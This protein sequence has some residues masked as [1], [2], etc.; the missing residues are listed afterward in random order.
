METS[1]LK[2]DGKLVKETLKVIGNSLVTKTGC[3]IYFPKHYVD[4]K[5]GSMI[6][7]VQ[8]IGY[9]AIVIDD[10]YYGVNKTAAMITLSPDSIA[11]VDVDDNPYMELKFNPGS[12]VIRELDLVKSS[13]VLFNIYDE[14]VAKGKTPWY[15]SYS[16]LGAIFDT[17]VYH[18]GVNLRASRSIMEMMAASRARDPANRA[19]Y[20]RN[21]LTKQSDL[22]KTEP[23]IIALR[24]VSY[25]ATNAVSRLLG[26][27]L[28]EGVSSALVN[29]TD[30]IEK[31]ES[32]LLT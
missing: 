28:N 27:Y 13:S 31:V 23:D 29:P 25:G 12:V 1:H 5:L 32:L 18:A 14:I 2:R 17:A 16:D 10:K 4:G 15:F 24:N 6:D 30:R 11:K 21:T 3:K 7:N 20:Y 22:E 19:D 9:Y 26:A 8:V